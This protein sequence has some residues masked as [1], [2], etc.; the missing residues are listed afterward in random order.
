MTFG[1]WA[2]RGKRTYTKTTP[3]KG[4][5]GEPGGG[6]QKKEELV[7]NDTAAKPVPRNREPTRPASRATQCACQQPREPFLQTAGKGGLPAERRPCRVTAAL[8]GAGGKG[9]SPEDPPAPC[10]PGMGRGGPQPAGS[11]SPPRPTS[12]GSRRGRSGALRPRHH[13]RR[14]PAPRSR[15]PAQVPPPGGLTLTKAGGAA[16]SSSRRAPWAPSS[17]GGGG[18]SETQT[19]V[20]SKSRAQRHSTA[21]SHNTLGPPRPRAPL[22]PPLHSA[23][24]ASPAGFLRPAPSAALCPSPWQPELASSRKAPRVRSSS[25]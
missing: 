16:A 22:R 12:P 23:G 24:P 18:A 8:P 3:Y 20:C 10:G 13:P 21:A 15:P 19:R 7:Q 1:W 17:R 6:E 4:A 11:R 2:S 25:T 9:P 5:W 14:G